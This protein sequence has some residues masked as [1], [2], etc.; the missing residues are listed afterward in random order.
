MTTQEIRIRQAV[1]DTVAAVLGEKIEA[2][3]DEVQGLRTQLSTLLAATPAKKVRTTADICRDFGYS[4]NTLRTSPWLL[5]NFGKSD[6]PGKTR[7]WKEAT[8]QNWFSG[9]MEAKRREWDRLS[10]K[11]KE[12]AK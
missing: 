11:Q 6:F 3:T 10:Y 2:L 1:S 8:Y 12:A 9:S 5:P 7:K 4:P